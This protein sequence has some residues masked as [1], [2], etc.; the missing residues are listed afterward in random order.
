MMDA[1]SAFEFVSIGS[2][3]TW[4]LHVTMT[5]YMIDYGQKDD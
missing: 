2:C 3:G 5:K 1:L 4:L